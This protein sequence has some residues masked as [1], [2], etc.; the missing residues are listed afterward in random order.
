M[1]HPKN[2]PEKDAENC[3]ERTVATRLNSD[4]LEVRQ[5]NERP[6]RSIQRA[7]PSFIQLPERIPSGKRVGMWKVTT[8]TGSNFQVP[9]FQRQ[10]TSVPAWRTASREMRIGNDCCQM[11]H[12]CTHPFSDGEQLRS[13]RHNET[14]KP[15][16]VTPLP[17]QLTFPLVAVATRRTSEATALQA[18]RCLLASVSGHRQSYRCL[19]ERV[20]CVRVE[21]I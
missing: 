5:V 18:C 11:R 15:R 6:A 9:T 8:G 21:S 12:S 13:D 20:Q 1:F 10:E 2:V 17:R 7:T 19:T 3:S 14:G 4:N 16:F